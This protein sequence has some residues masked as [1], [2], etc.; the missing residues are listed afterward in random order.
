MAYRREEVEIL[1]GHMTKDHGHVVG[2][3]CFCCSSGNVT[4]EVIT[5]DQ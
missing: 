3:D 2:R 4:G 1:K 5:E